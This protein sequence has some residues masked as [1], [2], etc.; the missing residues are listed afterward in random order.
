MLY[1]GY[2]VIIRRRKNEYVNIDNFNI[3]LYLIYRIFYIFLNTLIKYQI[4][5][6]NSFTHIFHNF[7]YVY[8]TNV[9]R[10]L[11]YASVVFNI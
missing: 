7:N 5:E 6:K 4:K 3:I 10:K 2:N 1:N 9:R 11:R 8:I